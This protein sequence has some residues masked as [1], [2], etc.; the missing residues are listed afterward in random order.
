M[1][2]QDT[3]LTGPPR[4]VP[5]S[6]RWDEVPSGDPGSEAIE[7]PAE[8]GDAAF[9]DAALWHAGSKNNSNGNR[10]GLFAYF[11]KYWVKRMDN[12][13]RQPLPA[14]LL[15]STDPRTRQLLGLG[16]RPGVTSYHG[17]DQTY[18]LRGEQ[19]IDF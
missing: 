3:A 17:D 13:F 7:V 2:M 11:G 15:D 10:I 16:L 18:N 12:N 1:Y 5:G 9:F 14:A 19:G 4:V 8:A 6:H